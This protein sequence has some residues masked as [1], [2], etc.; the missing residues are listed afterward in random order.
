MKVMWGEL[1]LDVQ[2]SVEPA[3]PA[4]GWFEPNVIIESIKLPILS[5]ACRDGVPLDLRDIED[6][7]WDRYC[8]DEKFQSFIDDQVAKAL[9]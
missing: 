5:G 7:I 8:E 3:D 9:S 1:E 2:V 6:F 4:V